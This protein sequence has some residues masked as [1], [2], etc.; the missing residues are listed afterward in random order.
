MKDILTEFATFI[1]L[2][3]NFHKCTLSPMNCDADLS[4]ELANIFGRAMGTMP[5]TYLVLSLGTSK[6]TE[7]DLMPLYA[8]LRED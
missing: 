4:H 7:Q 8:M 3:I 2:K 1:G 5:F 6:S